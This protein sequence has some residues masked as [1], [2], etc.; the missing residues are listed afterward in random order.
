MSAWLWTLSNLLQAK[1]N[2]NRSGVK[3]KAVSHPASVAS[4]FT[5]VDSK[6]KSKVDEWSCAICQ[7]C[8]TSELTLNEHLRGKKH[9]N[10]EA[11]L[12]AQGEQ[13]NFSIGKTTDNL[14]SEQ[15]EK[16]GGESQVQSN[17]E[18]K[19]KIDEQPMQGIRVFHNSDER[20][21]EKT[22]KLES[23]GEEKKKDRHIWCKICK[24]RVYSEKVMETHTKGKKHV[25]RLREFNQNGGSASEVQMEG[26]AEKAK[27]D[28]KELSFEVVDQVADRD[29]NWVIID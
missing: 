25:A 10:K 27:D 12:R 4:E 17:T 22:Q 19:K 23:A 24:I 26:Y 6:K 9:Q 29:T 7:V 13:K 18:D 16:I 8:A 3:R 28:V 5:S 20:N 14:S 15:G 2:A 1:P 21:G 11:A